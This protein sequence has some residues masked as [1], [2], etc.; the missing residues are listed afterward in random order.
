MSATR[1]SSRSTRGMRRNGRSPIQPYSPDTTGRSSQTLLE[2]DLRHES[3]LARDLVA[4]QRIAPIV[5][6]TIGD[7][8][9]SELGAPTI[10]RV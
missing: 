10:F 4:A 9:M 7:G 2:A 3:G 8:V 1:S 6:G 5:A